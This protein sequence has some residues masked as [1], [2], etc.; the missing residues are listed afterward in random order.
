MDSESNTI[1]HWADE[2][3]PREKLLLKG[4]HSLTDAELLAILLRTGAQGLNVIDLSKRLLYLAGNDLNELGK[5]NVQDV[6]R[7]KTLKGMGKTKA[8]T[9]VAALE[10]GRRRQGAEAKQRSKITGSRDAYE[11]LAPQMADLNE[12]Q[13]RVLLLNQANK[14]LA[15]ELIS[16]G[17]RTATI[18]DVRVIFR[19]ALLA[20]AVGIIVAHNHPSGNLKPSQADIDLTRKLKQAGDLMDIKVLDHL[21]ITEHSY[22]SF[23]D[24]GNM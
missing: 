15:N 19:Q 3:K 5:W 7:H 6:L 11:L 21:I 16:F 24:K 9:L 4:K 22:Y 8:I 17:G 20:Q 1:K 13:F 18:A 2:D 14:V 10:L 12:E 23:A